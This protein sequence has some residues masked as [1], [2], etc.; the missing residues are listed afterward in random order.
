MIAITNT[1]LVT[2]VAQSRILYGMA[3]EGVV[4]AVF[5][6][7]H[8][9]RRSPYVALIFG[10]IVIGALLVVG[11]AIRSGQA[12][13]PLRLANRGRVPFPRRAKRP[14][15]GELRRRRAG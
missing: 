4:P 14:R 9:V 1:A 3:R 10:A 6:R 8:P 13:L 12:D 15:W 5:A 7:V 11:A 2:V